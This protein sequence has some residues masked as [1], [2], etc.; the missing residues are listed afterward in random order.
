M[1]NL[2]RWPLFHRPACSLSLNR[3]ICLGSSGRRRMTSS[4]EHRPQSQPFI[5]RAHFRFSHRVRTPSPSKGDPKQQQQSKHIP[6]RPGASEIEIPGAT[7]KISTPLLIFQRAALVYMLSMAACLAYTG[8][9]GWYLVLNGRGDEVED[10][11][12][13]SV[14][15]DATRWPVDATRRLLSGGDSGP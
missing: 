11:T 6:G 1:A 5:P 12:P 4:D 14:V 7:P 13:L 9:H 2:A 15:W 3:R 8:V 10:Q